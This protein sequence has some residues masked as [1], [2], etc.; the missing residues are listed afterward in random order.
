[1][2]F[3]LI[4]FMKKWITKGNQLNRVIPNFEYHENGY[5]CIGFI[6]WSMHVQLSSDDMGQFTRFHYLFHCKQQ[7]SGESV[8]R[9]TSPE[10]MLLTYIK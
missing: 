4:L 3:V 2:V 6:K 1:M 10:P 8:H 7:S 9:L 5:F